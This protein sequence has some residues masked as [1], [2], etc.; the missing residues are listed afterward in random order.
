MARAFAIALGCGFFSLV[1]IGYMM[2]WPRSAL[3]GPA[4][5]G[6]ILTIGGI[7][8][9]HRYKAAGEAPP[10]PGWVATGERFR[11][12]ATGRMV[13]VYHKEATGERAYVAE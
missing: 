12:D 2:G 10:G 11:D 5:L 6:A 13:R 4:V 7:F 1:L 9:R 3:V 8:E